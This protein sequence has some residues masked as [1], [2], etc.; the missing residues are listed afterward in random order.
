MNDWSL[1]AVHILNSQQH[2]TKVLCCH[3]LDKLAFAVQFME[4][5]AAFRILHNQVEKF[6]ILEMIVKL[7][8]MSV[9]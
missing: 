8:D 2:L 9:V 1:K 4:E 6:F 3:T 7:D 5:V